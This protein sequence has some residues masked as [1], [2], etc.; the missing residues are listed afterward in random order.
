MLRTVLACL[1]LTHFACVAAVTVGPQPTT[2]SVPV[3]KQLATAPFA[4][5]RIAGIRAD[6][7]QGAIL[8]VFFDH[9]RAT[10]ATSVNDPR[11]AGSVTILPPAGSN[12][13]NVIVSPSRRLWER[14]RT[15]RAVDVTLVPV[16]GGKTQVEAVEFTTGE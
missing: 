11:Y 3:P 15:E 1:V 10:R 8:R 6:P 13:R 12:P 4:L 16:S 7:E 9:P 2:V 14:V 5:V